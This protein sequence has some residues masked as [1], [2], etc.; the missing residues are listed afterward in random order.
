MAVKKK[1]KP[2]D[3]TLIRNRKAF[4]D[5]QI[6]DRFE[7][8]ISLLGTEVKSCRAAG[9]SLSEA[10]ISIE[11]GEAWLVGAH[12][13]QY[14]HGNRFNHETKRRRRL[15]LH[16]KEIIK[17]HQQTR[18]KGL[19]LIPLSFYIVRGKIKVS[20]GVGKGKTQSDKRDT[21]RKK[22]DDRDARRAMSQ[23]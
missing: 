13:N 11:R 3:N 1:K 23:R 21:L 22:Q 4:H 5:Y 2:N 14:D 10:Y 19:T 20:I 7:A 17:L 15:L 12:I 8:G 18:E 16:K 9:I 6:L